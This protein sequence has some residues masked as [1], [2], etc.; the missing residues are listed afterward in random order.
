MVL[1]RLLTPED[2]GLIA[3]VAAVTG[4]MLL[5]GVVC[6]A[7]IPVLFVGPSPK[8]WL[9]LPVWL[10]WSLGWTAALSGLTAWGVLRYWKDD[11]LE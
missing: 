7:T 4:F 11:D 9:G 6:L 1:A 3:M 10:W 2:F 5:L 8:L